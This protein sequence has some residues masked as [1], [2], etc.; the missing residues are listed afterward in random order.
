[1]VDHGA[2]GSPLTL[3]AFYPV[4]AFPDM[5]PEDIPRAYRA[6]R[7]FHQL[8]ADPLFQIRYPFSA[9][10]LVGFDNRR[11][12]HGRDGFDPG[13]GF[14]HLRGTYVDHDEMY[15]RL[16]VLSRHAAT[17]TGAGATLTN[18]TTET[19]TVFPEVAAK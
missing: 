3:R 18:N 9:G 14:R 5:A 15:S 19:P 2:P 16:R 12:L 17:T 7:R 6:A 4:R 1:M 10:D 13:S 11:I 8:A